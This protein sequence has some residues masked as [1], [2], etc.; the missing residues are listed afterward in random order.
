MP[1]STQRKQDGFTSAN[2]TEALRKNWDAIVE[3]ANPPAPPQ[4]PRAP[5]PPQTNT[6]SPPGN[7][8]STR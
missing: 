4:P 8:R 7:Q 2:P 5:E 6:G 1:E 3:V